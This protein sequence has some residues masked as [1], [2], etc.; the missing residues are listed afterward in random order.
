M[1][2]GYLGGRLAIYFSTRSCTIKPHTGCW[3]SSLHYYSPDAESIDEFSLQR[4]KG[5][6]PSVAQRLNRLGIFSSKDL[7]FHL[8]LRYQDRSHVKPIGALRR[9]DEVTICGEIYH[10]EI[11][12]GK[13]RMLLSR[14]SDGTGFI[15]LRFFHFNAQQKARLTTGVFIQCF[16]EVRAGINGMEMVHPEY[17]LIESGDSQEAENRLTAIYPTTEGLGQLSIRSIIDKLLGNKSLVDRILVE[18]LPEDVLTQGQFLPLKDAVLFLHSPPVGTDLSLLQAGIHPAQRRLAFEEL[19]A[20]QLSLRLLRMNQKKDSA[21]PLVSQGI[22]KAKIIDDLPFELTGAQQNVLAETVKDLQLSSPMQRLIQGDVGSGKTIVAALAAAEAVEAGFQVA[23]MAPTE[24]L[25]EQ[26]KLNFDKFLKP[27]KVRIELLSGKSPAKKRRPVLEGLLSGDVQ[28]VVGTQALFQESVG[29]FKLGLIIIDEQHR[30]GV[31]QR[32]SLREKGS[33]KSGSERFYPHQL[34]MTATPIPRTLAQTAYADLDISV[35]NELPPGRTPIDTVVVSSHR[36]EE[37]I[38]RVSS[39]CKEGNQA[40]WVCPLIE[41]SE[42]L[43]CQAAQET[44]NLLAAI[45]PDLKIGLVHGRL[46]S[47]EKALVMQAFKEGEVDLLVATT[48]I[49][50]GV[51]VPNAS[52]MIIENAERLG[53][54][55]LH[56]LRG[57]VGRGRRQSSCVLLYGEKLSKLGKERL[58]ILRETND[59]FV[60]AQRDLELRG[61]GELLGIRQTGLMV[62]RIADL[63]RD[64]DLVPEVRKYADE[65][66]LGN[67]RNVGPIINRWIGNNAK[68]SQV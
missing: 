62:F 43:Q 44:A 39:A 26:H 48:V 7:L 5:V 12:F 64:S 29:F 23:L 45:L 27:L 24:L 33:F 53:L 3:Y 37:V 4:L 52:L 58:K 50:V 68:Y 40:Y 66:L 31:H 47:A 51:D 57:R 16:G 41:E 6:G 18:L 63:S 25:A 10:T 2:A 67:N 17:R 36:R 28:I 11:K 35:I 49:E 46:K 19:L 30:F 9:G 56:Q 60:V 13:K 20:Q 32:H 22:F 55:Q 42:S 61:P 14:I 21:P 1:R 54:S 59:G 38:A 15:T 65:M 34:V 8:P